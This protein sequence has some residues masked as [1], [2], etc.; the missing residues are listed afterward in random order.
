MLGHRLVAESLYISTVVMQK[1]TIIGLMVVLVACLIWTHEHEGERVL[2]IKAAM[3][4][5]IM[6][7]AIGGLLVLL[8]TEAD[9]K[10]GEAV[11]G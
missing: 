9:A 8:A 10:N 4:A 3:I 7:S 2:G 5:S 11:A 1:R 6:S